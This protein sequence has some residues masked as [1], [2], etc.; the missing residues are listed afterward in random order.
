MIEPRDK[1]TIS[2]QVA[3]RVAYLGLAAFVILGIIFFRLWYLQV[4][5]SDQSLAQARSNR[6]RDEKIPAPRGFILDRDNQ[7]LVE[8]R[9]STIVTLNPSSL[10]TAYRDA[11]LEWGRNEGLRLKKP[12]AVRPKPAPRPTVPAQLT[13]LFQ[14]LATTL[15]ISTT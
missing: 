4:L 9:R 13:P 8:N 1:T 12:K 14:R 15:D 6:L 7:P 11:I 3:L 10:P 2:P 5:A